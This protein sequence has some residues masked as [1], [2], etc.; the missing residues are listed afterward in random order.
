LGSISVVF[1]GFGGDGMGKSKEKGSSYLGEL[2][3]H[4]PFLCSGRERG[5]AVDDQVL[6]ER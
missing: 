2:L 5:A 1:A 4:A 3:I 6:S